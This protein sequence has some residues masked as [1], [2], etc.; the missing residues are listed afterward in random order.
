MGG[1]GGS[2]S[3]NNSRSCGNSKNPKDHGVCSAL[4]RDA[5]ECKGIRLCAHE[6]LKQ[7]CCDLVAVARMETPRVLL[8]SQV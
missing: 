8:L 1:D 3:S 2:R 5:R 4:R 7:C 6:A